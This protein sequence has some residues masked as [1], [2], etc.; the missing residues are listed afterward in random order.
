[1]RLSLPS[2]DEKP[3]LG[4]RERKKAQTRAAVQTI[5]LRLFSEQGYEA[6][7]V[8][9]IIRLAD[10]SESTFFRYFPT[11]ED[12][13]LRDDF[14]PIILELFREQP[15]EVGVL[16]SLRVAMRSIFGNLTAE[17]RAEQSERLAL[18][19]SVPSLRAASLAQF[20]EMMEM[21]AAAIAERLGRPADDFSILV[22]SGAIVGSV[23]AVMAALA[24]DPTAEVWE[25]MDRAIAQL[26][27]GLDLT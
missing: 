27:T 26:E 2:L 5:A 8:D 6:T 7:T 21:F 18:V 13:V 1:M 20:S 12:L 11:K 3:A 23:M 4:L 15:A 16:E 14:D 9:Q 24:D 22:L 19:L 25:L 17:Q 10:I